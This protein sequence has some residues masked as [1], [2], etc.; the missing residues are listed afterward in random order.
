[1]SFTSVSAQDYNLRINHLID[2][3]PA[4]HHL[5]DLF[6]NV[7]RN[8]AI[9]EAEEPKLQGSL[10]SEI[11]MVGKD[12]KT[13]GRSAQGR[14]RDAKNEVM[15]FKR[16]LEG[17]RAELRP[18]VIDRVNGVTTQ[19]NGI[20]D[21]IEHDIT[22]HLNNPARAAT[23]FGPVDFAATGAG[24][25]AN[26]FAPGPSL[27]VPDAE[28]GITSINAAGSIQFNNKTFTFQG[29]QGEALRNELTRFREEV[30][31]WHTDRI[32]R[33]DEMISGLG[34]QLDGV[35]SFIEN[36]QRA[37]HAKSGAAPLG[38]MIESVHIPTPP[39][40]HVPAGAHGEGAALE[41]GFRMPWMGAGLG[42]GAGFVA[43]KMTAKEGES[44]TG[45]TLVFTGA[46][47]ALGGAIQ[48]F[49][50]KAGRASTAVAEHLAPALN[51]MGPML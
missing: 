9:R 41:A 8:V 1:M 20:A 23:P 21:V 19:M 10:L 26:P 11:A 34:K 38:K 42:A 3:L 17:R 4:G 6:S 27:V 35:V 43:D 32:N 44:N 46:G 5:R 29:K 37:L 45:R 2:Q 24:R 16:A 12:D 22:A 15:E 48:T 47:A 33:A 25:P 7:N 13:R 18:A 40:P 14:L 49:M 36:E 30:A 31:T 51:H 50:G 28:L 39:P